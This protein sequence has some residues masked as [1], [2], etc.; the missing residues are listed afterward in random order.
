[1]IAQTTQPRASITFPDRSRSL[2]KLNSAR[3]EKVDSSLKDLNSIPVCEPCVP[4]GIWTSRRI[5]QQRVP[6]PMMS[7]LDRRTREFLEE[8]PAAFRRGDPG[9]ASSGGGGLPRKITRLLSFSSFFPYYAVLQSATKWRG[10]GRG[11]SAGHL[12]FPH[13]QQGM[14]EV[15]CTFSRVDSAENAEN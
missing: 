1:M 11:V 3:R 14:L 9:R 6:I 13:T 10:R 5:Q 4:R 7:S 12:H 2:S 8:E 15:P